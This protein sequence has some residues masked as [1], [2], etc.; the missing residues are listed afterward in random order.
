M[1]DPSS[2]APSPPPDTDSPRR[3]FRQDLITRQWVVVAPART[4]RPNDFAESPPSEAAASSPVDGCPFC[5]GHED[6]IPRIVWELNGR[7][8][9]PADWH[10]R[11]LPNKYPA[12]TPD[13]AGRADAAGLYRTRP[14]VGRQ[15]VVVD[16]PR[17]GASLAAMPESQIE[18]ILETYQS[19]YRALREEDLFPFIFR[20]HGADAGASL[21]HPHS[22]I[23]ATDFA[24]PHVEQEERRARAH[25]TETG[26]C[27]YCEMIGRE[28]ADG[29][30]IV[31]ATDSFIAFVPYAAQ[32][33]YEMWILPR[34][35]APEFGRMD[36]P[37]RADLAGTL[38]TVLSALFT[39]CGDPDYNLF[40][41]TGLNHPCD[42]EHV[43]W[44]L[45]IRPRLSLDAGFELGT[46]LKVN[47]SLPERDAEHLRAA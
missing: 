17:H 7:D 6:D 42:A 25:A 21:A 12:L 47:P 1:Q 37:M 29:D 31:C 3:E 24:P 19:R 16:S 26:R 40:V 11:V 13:R 14:G 45:R 43:H 2:E 22:Q 39:Q 5:P 10:T 46:G 28:L 38:R 20:N 32:V 44:S 4:D 36:A 30:R 15:E 35:H 18:A 33:P 41:R 8:R 9:D 27:G 23:I 34:E